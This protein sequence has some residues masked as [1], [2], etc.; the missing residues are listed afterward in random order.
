METVLKSRKNIHF[1]A[2]NLPFSFAARTIEEDQIS[3][4]SSFVKPNND[5]SFAKEFSKI[6]MPSLSIMAKNPAKEMNFAKL[7]PINS[8]T[9]RFPYQRKCRSISPPKD[10]V[11]ACERRQNCFFPEGSPIVPDNSLQGCWKEDSGMEEDRDLQM[12]K[13]QYLTIVQQANNL[14][15]KSKLFEKTEELSGT[16]EFD[17]WE[18]SIM[19]KMQLH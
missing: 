2:V 15:F 14:N 17:E 3:T 19:K 6:G 9:G 10:N 13:Q 4:S 1:A 11:G 12:L 5:Q 8:P 18:T 7:T 16:E